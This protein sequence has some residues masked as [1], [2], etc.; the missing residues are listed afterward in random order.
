MNFPYL[1]TFIS[2]LNK[3]VKRKLLK[4]CFALRN[5]TGIEIGGPSNFFLPK[6]Y[7]PIYAFAKKIDGVNFSSETVWEGKL[8]E[9]NNYKYYNKKTGFQYLIE[10]SDLSKIKNNSYDFL[11][12]CHSLEHVANAIKALKEWNRILKPGASLVLALPDKRYTFD[13]KRLYTSFEHLLK[14]FENNVDEHDETCFEEVLQLHD[15][16][17]D[18]GT[19]SMEE[20]KERIRNTFSNRCVHHHV[21]S[22]ELVKQVLEYC[23]FSV[24]LQQEITNLHLFTIAVKN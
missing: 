16:S 18:P 7:F 24:L 23:G 1:T 9:G 15:L 19:N 5:K 8:S 4:K 21:F 17:M 12:S 20:F 22:T 14:D 13:H 2:Y 6:G 3:P 11:L 10:A